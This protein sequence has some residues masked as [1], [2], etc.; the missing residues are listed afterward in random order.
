MGLTIQDGIGYA[1]VYKGNSIVARIWDNGNG[2]HFVKVL[3]DGFDM[4]VNSTQEALKEISKR[5][6]EK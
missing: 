2:G 1:D 4:S 6:G 3:T 5:L